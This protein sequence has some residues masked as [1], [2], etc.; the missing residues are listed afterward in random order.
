[1]MGWMGCMTDD[2]GGRGVGGHQV[3]IDPAAHWETEE[4]AVWMQ[5]SPTLWQQRASQATGSLRHVS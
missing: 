4:T 3:S 1:M 5:V 2:A